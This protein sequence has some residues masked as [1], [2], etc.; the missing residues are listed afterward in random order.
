MMK[1]D[2]KG[3]STKS[4]AGTHTNEDEKSDQLYDQ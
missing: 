1:E 2:T 3:R 4:Y